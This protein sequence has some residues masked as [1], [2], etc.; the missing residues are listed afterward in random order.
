MS[1]TQD[2]V[3]ELA[4]SEHQTLF[5]A[6]K[7]GVAKIIDNHAPGAQG[8]STVS[9]VSEGVK[10]LMANF[11]VLKK[12]AEVCDELE[13]MVPIKE[14]TLPVVVEAGITGFPKDIVLKCAIA[15]IGA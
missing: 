3:V 11:M 9:G 13:L 8:M 7:L 5:R 15:C 12:I 6:P 10:I 4:F 2:E 1:K 14:Q